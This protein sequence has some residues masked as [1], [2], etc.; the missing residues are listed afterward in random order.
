MNLAVYDQQIN[1]KT[2]ELETGAPS[3]VAGLRN[4]KMIAVG[5]L[6]YPLPLYLKIEDIN[7]LSR[8]EALKMFY[9]LAAFKYPGY[10]KVVYDGV[11]ADQVKEYIM[12]NF[13][14]EE[15]LAIAAGIN[16][17]ALFSEEKA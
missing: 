5:E 2:G 1:S 9:V 4:G 15:R 12:K 10:S 7:G 3:L 13:S 6:P 17:E 8:D 11:S 16:V 14:R